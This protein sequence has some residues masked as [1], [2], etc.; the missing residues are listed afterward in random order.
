MSFRDPTDAPCTAAT[1]AVRAGIDRDTAYGAVTPPIVLSSN[2][3]FDGFGNKR[4]Y[5]YTR[6]GNPTRD[7]LGEA[8][9]ELEGGAGGVITSTG[10]GAIN[11]V[12]NAVLQPGD[13]LV[14]PH[15]AYGGSWRLFNALAKKGHFA[16]ITADLT[17]PR[18]LADALAQSPK[19]VLIETPSNPLLRI[20]DLRFVIEAA[21]KVGAL[22]VVDNTFL[23][24][25]LQKP[26]DFGADLVLHSTTKYINGHSDVVGGAVVARDAQLHQQLVWWANA[27][28]LTGSP[29]DAF[30]TLRGLRTLDARLRVHQENADA[31]AALL[32][33][34]AAVNRVYFPGLASHPGHALAARQQKGFGA[35]MSFELEGGEAAVRAFVDGLRYFTLAES[36]G[37]VESLIAHP[38]SMT[39]AA[40]TAEARA[41]AGIS[42]GLLRLSIGI[43]SADDLLID[44]RA[45]LARAEATLT[46]ASRKQVDA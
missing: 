1:A 18:S 34:H 46:A 30:L 27:L 24:P 25:A 7:L 13:T 15:D 10:M 40:M 2:F 29:F 38:A 8:L 14:V 11:L 32:D 21:R 16:L 22:T 28:G 6:S 45:G 9:A 44:L 36:L 41:A 20:T 3:S 4:Q 5:D 23:S 31:I 17:D 12:L 19:L 26:L 37:G 43:E 35:M 39:H 42:D 33:G